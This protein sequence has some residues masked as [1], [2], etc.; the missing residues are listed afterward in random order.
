M[1]VGRL[2]LIAGYVD[3]YAWNKDK[4]A[5]ILDSNEGEGGVKQTQAKH[6]PSVNKA[7]SV[8]KL[9]R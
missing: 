7:M 4:G 5:W 3:L 6:L 1:A 9:P 2:M 8:E